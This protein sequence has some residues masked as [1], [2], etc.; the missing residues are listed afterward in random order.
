MG[1]NWLPSFV[2]PTPCIQMN[3]CVVLLLFYLIEGLI[4]YMKY[5]HDL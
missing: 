3:Y 2:Y 1:P 4:L 5:D